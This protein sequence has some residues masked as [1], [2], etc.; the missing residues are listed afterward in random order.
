LQF[1]SSP[2]FEDIAM[3]DDIWLNT[4]I[5]AKRG[6]AK[7]QV[8]KRHELTIEGQGSFHYVYG[9]YAKPVLIIDPGDVVAVETED[10]F[11]ALSQAKKTAQQQSCSFPSSIRSAARLP[12]TGSRRA[13]AW[14]CISMPWRQGARS[15]RA[16]P[17]S[18]RNSVAWS[19]RRQPQ[20][21]IRRCPNG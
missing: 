19:E 5:M 8:G 12:S 17:A 7:G 16:R 11:G 9:P 14:P 6:L 2:S 21:S 20:C 13:I 10:A 18:F 15:R 3:T 4:S 1:A